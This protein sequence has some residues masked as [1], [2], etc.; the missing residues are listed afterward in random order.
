VTVRRSP[1]GAIRSAYPEVIGL[2]GAMLMDAHRSRR[3]KVRRRAKRLPR[4][5]GWISLNDTPS[6]VLDVARYLEMSGCG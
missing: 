4:G 1:G 3:R 2:A 6:F 5:R